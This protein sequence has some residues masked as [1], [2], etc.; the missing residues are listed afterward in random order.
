MVGFDS[1]LALENIGID[2][3][4]GQESDAVEFRS[5]FCE[6]IDKLFPD[7]VAFLFWIRHSGEFVQEAVHCIDVD[8]FGAKFIAEDLYHLFGLSF[9]KQPVVDMYADEILANG[10]DKKRCDN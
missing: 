2:G 4:L 1:V 5:L 7:D 8:K 9:A 6:Y 10:L 3:S